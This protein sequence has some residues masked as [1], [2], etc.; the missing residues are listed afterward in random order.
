M[1]QLRQIQ[2]FTAVVQS[3]SFVKAADRLGTSKAVVSRL[4]QEL[5]TQ[6]GTRLLNRTT[7]RLSLTDSGRDYFERCRQILDDLAEANAAASATS[8]QPAGRLKINAPLTFGNLHLA[9]LWGEFLKVYPLV[10]LDL[11]LSDR[12][13]DLV[14]EG[15]DLA[16]RISAAASLPSSSLVAR[17]LSS[18]RAILCASPAYLQRARPIERLADLAEHSVMAY[19]YW[20][21][22]DVWSFD[23]PQGRESVT[24]HPRLR[25]NSGDTCRAAAL[26]DQGIV[27]QPGFLVG[28]DLKA[29]RLQEILPL[30]RGPA[31]TIQ[32]VYPSRKHL[33]GKV[34]VMVDFLAQAFKQ[35]GWL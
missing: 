20:S 35:P 25:A 17:P 16:I 27:L 13:V 12:V 21:G 19:T 15:F 10:E 28:P 2:A 8:T 18:D 33:S 14:E 11:T 23:G 32:A 3:G 9:P 24:T 26:A 30:H 7:R 5:E 31:L 34:R 1:D 29:G 22:G 4:L 6:L